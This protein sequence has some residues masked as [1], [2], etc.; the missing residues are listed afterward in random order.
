MATIVLASAKGS[1]GVTTTALALATQWPILTGH[2]SLLFDADEA[3]GDTAPGILR[4]AAPPE[5]GVLPLATAHKTD[6]RTA[7]TAASVR[8]DRGV[9][10]IPGIPDANRIGALPI[11]WDVLVSSLSPGAADDPAGASPAGS[12]P[13][14]CD[15]IVDA[16]RVGASAAGRPWFVQADLILLVLAPTLPA[17][18]ATERL[19]ASWPGTRT[20]L[21]AVVVDQPSPY[22]PRQTA[23]ALRLPLL[24]AVAYEPTRAA[25]F[26]VGAPPVRNHERSSFQGDIARLTAAI[27]HD[28]GGRD[29]D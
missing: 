25:V 19:L 14:A 16:G 21:R 17:V 13:P 29:D 2:D 9:R 3:G 26:S 27:A 1:P 22:S 10:L 7:V 12:A 11:S 6:P 20:P 28:I 18:R 15:V 5:A 23:E 8:L 24:G 4:G